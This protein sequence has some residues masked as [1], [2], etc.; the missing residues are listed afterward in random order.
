MLVIHENRG[1]TPHFPTVVNRLAG[2]GYA[3]LAVDLLSSQGGTAAVTDPAQVQ[4]ALG[5][6]PPEQ[7]VADLRAGLDELAKRVPGAN[8]GAMGFCF[9]GGMVWRLLAAKEARLKAAIPFYGTPP[10]PADFSGAKA[11]VLAIYGGLDA[12]V[13]A[14]REKA[15]AALKAAGLTYDV[16]VFEGADHAFFNDTGPRYNAEAA[17]TAYTDVLSW[18]GTH[19]S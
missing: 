11:A 19:L 18:F 1:L 5:G 9:G 12:R 17:K 4:A 14:T 7:L 15:E 3:A 10:D 13:N 2:D 6:A 16:N 8:L